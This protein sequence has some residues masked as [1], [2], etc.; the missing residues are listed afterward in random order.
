MQVKL[1]AIVKIFV[2]HHQIGPPRFV[3]EF[4]NQEAACH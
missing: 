2:D 3:R 1:K 4:A